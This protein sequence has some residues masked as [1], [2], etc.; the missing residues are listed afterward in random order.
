MVLFVDLPDDILLKIFNLCPKKD[1]LPFFTCKP[2]HHAC[3][4]SWLLHDYLVV[5]LQPD[6]SFPADKFHALRSYGFIEDV[7]SEL[8]VILTLSTLKLLAAKFPFVLKRKSLTIINN[9]SSVDFDLIRALFLVVE[10]LSINYYCYQKLDSSELNTFFAGNNRIMESLNAKNNSVHTNILLDITGS[11]SQRQLTAIATGGVES[12][13]LQV[14][15]DDFKHEIV[16]TSDE[17]LENLKV[18]TYNPTCN[19]SLRSCEHVRLM[20]TDTNVKNLCA[21]QMAEL[22]ELSL[23]ISHR[24][25]TMMNTLMFGTSETLTTLYI[26]LQGMRFE[27]FSLHK[28]A[29]NLQHLLIADTSGSSIYSSRSQIADYNASAGH[30][31]FS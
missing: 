11:T 10:G 29:P 21:S 14:S 31:E 22:E 17:Y 23:S 6:A 12:F 5:K 26:I 8:S 13:N 30:L 4:R 9:L 3:I 2:A 20:V 1:L 28:F 25:S 7:V 24:N 15:S 27:P 18:L 19:L 16:I